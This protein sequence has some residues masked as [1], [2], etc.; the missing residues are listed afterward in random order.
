M[1]LRRRDLIDLIQRAVEQAA[2]DERDWLTALE[3]AI[4][5]Q[6][7]EWAFEGLATPDAPTPPE[8]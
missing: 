8:V 3:V 1:R 2:D 6:D 5:V 4:D 7:L